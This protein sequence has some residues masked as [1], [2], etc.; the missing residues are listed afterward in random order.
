MSTEIE[1]RVVQLEMNNKSLEKNSKQSIKTLEKL[2]KALEFKNG[3]KSFEDVEKAAEKCNFEPLLKAA[4]TVSTRFSTMGIIGVRALERITDKALD[5]GAALVKSLTIDQITAG[6]SKYEQKTS[7]I[8][9]LVNSTGLSVKEI[10]KYLDQLMWFSDETSYSFTEMVNALATMSASGGDIN[11]LIPMIQG[12]ANATAFAGKGATEFSRIMYNLNQS[13]TAGYLSYMDWK[14]VEQ[15]GAASK[16]LK[17][18]LLDTAVAERKITKGQAD[19]SNFNNLLSK[20]VFTRDI[21]EKSFGYFNEMTQKAYEMIGTL[22][23]QGNVIE[24]ASQAYEILGQQ[25]D[26]VSLRA[27]KSA[28]EAKSFSEAINATKDAVSS[29]WLKMFESIFGDYEQQV[30][31]WTGL[32]EGLYNIFAAP[33]SDVAD[34]IDE[35]FQSTPIGTIEESLADCGIELDAFKEK[36]V[37]TAKA[38]GKFPDELIDATAGSAKSIQDLLSLHW[39]DSSMVSSVMAGYSNA[40]ESGEKVTKEFTTAAELADRM[41]TGEFGN[42][43]NYKELTKNLQEAGYDIANAKDIFKLAKSDP[44]AQIRLLGELTDKNAVSLENAAE[45]AKNFNHEFYASNSGRTIA[46]EGVKNILSAIGDRIAMVKKAW[47]DIFPSATAGSIKNAIIAFHQWTETLKMGEDEGNRIYSVASKVFGALKTGISVVGRIIG[48]AGNLVKSV[49]RI[50]K[51]FFALAPVQGFISSIRT[52]L[53]DIYHYVGNK[54]LNAL[55]W[56]E[57]FINNKLN[58]S[59]DDLSDIFDRISKKLAPLYK[60]AKRVGSYTLGV[61]GRIWQ[62]LSPYANFLYTNLVSPFAQFISEVVNSDDPIATLASGVS[63]FIKKVSTG[64]SNVVQKIK[65]FSISDLFKSANTKFKE[66]LD[67]FPE[68][69]TAFENLQ[70]VVDNLKEHLDF[71]QLLAIFTGAALVV[72]VGKFTKALSDLS[73]VAVEIKKTLGNLNSIIKR[74]S[75]SGFA[76]NMKAI[77]IAIGVLAASLFLLSMIPSEDLS[78]VAKYLGGMMAVLIVVSAVAAIV[79]TKLTANKLQKVRGIIKPLLALSAA[80]LIL[81]IASKNASIAAGEGEGSWK[82]VWKILVVI[83]GLAVELVGVTA[84]LGLLGGKITVAAIVLMVVSVAILKLAQAV[85]LLENIK[86]SDDAIKLGWIVAAIMIVGILASAVTKVGKG[87][88][89]FANAA[90]GILAFVASIYLLTITFEKITSEGMKETWKKFGEHSSIIIPVLAILGGLVIALIAISKRMGEMSKS[91]AKL[92]IGVFAMVGA[93]YLITLLFERLSDFAD[94]DHYWAGWLGVFLIGVI[95]V[96]MVETLGRAAQMSDGGK[97]ALKLA[98]TVIVMTVAIGVMMLLFKAMALLTK[99]MTVEEIWSAIGY[100][101]V[102][103]VI[104]GALTIVA[105]KAAQLGGG[106]GLTIII[107]VIAGMVALVLM[108]ITLTS[109]KLEQIGPAILGILGIAIA[110]GGVIMAVGYAAQAASKNKGGAASL[111]AMMGILLAVGISLSLLAKYGWTQLLAAAVSISAVLAV[112]AG[113]M[114]YMS[115]AIQAVGGSAGSVV[116]LFAVIGVLAAIAGALYF[117]APMPWPQLLAAAGAMAAVLF[118]VAFAMQILGNATPNIVNVLLAV[119]LLRTIFFGLWAIIPAMEAL[120]KVDTMSL[121]INMGI[122]LAAVLLLSL[123][124]A[125]LAAAMAAFPPL[126]LAFVV[127]IGIFLAIAVMMAAVSLAIYTFADAA[128]RLQGVDLFSIAGGMSTMAGAMALVA[129]AGVGLLIGNIGIYAFILAITIL[130]ASMALAS[131][132]ITAFNFALIALGNT[133]SA[134]ANAFQNANGNILGGLANL[135][136]EFAKSAESTAGSAKLMWD[137]IAGGGDQDASGILDGLVSTSGEKG[138]QGGS[139]YG[140]EFTTTAS[141]E[142]SN[143][144]ILSEVNSDAETKGVEG[145]QAYSLAYTENTDIEID[146]ESVFEESTEASKTAG[147]DAATAYVDQFETDFNAGFDELSPDIQSKLGDLFKGGGVDPSQGFSGMGNFGMTGIDFSGTDSDAMKNDISK[148]AN[149]M[150]STDEFN[151]AGQENTKAFVAGMVAYLGSGEASESAKTA[152][153]TWL[154]ENLTPTD[155]WETMTPIGTDIATKIEQEINEAFV[156][157]ADTSTTSQSLL[158]LLGNAVNGTDFTSIGSLIS[159]N[160]MGSVSTSLSSGQAGGEE[161]AVGNFLPLLTSMVAGTDATEPANTLGLSF[162]TKLGA[163]LTSVKNLNDL[164][165]SGVSMGNEVNSGGQSVDTTATGSYWGQGL[166]DGV[167]AWAQRIWQAGYDLA[168][169]LISGTQSGINSHSPSKEAYKLGVY[170][171]MGLIN[172]VVAGYDEVESVAY[173]LGTRAC[174]GLNEG[175]QNG[176]E[177]GIT[178]VIDMSDVMDTLDNFD[179][180]YRPTIKP[181][182]DM[183]DVDPALSNM[184]A[185]AS[186]MG[187]RGVEKSQETEPST[188]ASFNF[189]QNNYSPKALSRIDIYRQ[190]RNQFSTVKEM[191][192]K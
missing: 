102:L 163:S 12:V 28:Q 55:Q 165:N 43:W 177:G 181:R 115:K 56:C 82:K 166:K 111:F 189:T 106:K 125:G 110:L 129:L 178:P 48:L 146:N 153:T 109:F 134:I 17:Q 187:N 95:V 97:G 59:A 190:T 98:A 184:N 116:S 119:L 20:K 159:T 161:G 133:I 172:A 64:L 38:S 34:L 73:G 18:I 46:I 77:S 3:R 57:N 69:K 32:S 89:G 75:G 78:R 142:I 87:M 174:D 113:A 11:S 33:L 168:Q 85:K 167:W 76:A 4:D 144:D 10:N 58:P 50:G 180:T 61:L 52:G 160:V 118:S 26:T 51:A 120:A 47:G 41:M 136:D 19:I 7:S 192:K 88:S 128:E 81:S 36:L 171:D 143:G 107:G 39:V 24:T 94:V 74:K 173:S 123:I 67:A 114:D 164:N 90:L 186:Y 6:Y 179:S 132:S 105:G 103:G 79:A 141:A 2:D 183:S 65:N 185:V 29:Q 96:L 71:G 40:L 154:A 15:A 27:A 137:A 130:G 62:L 8:Q 169:K 68:L 86:L 112:L 156:S 191:I 16:Q 152:I 162:I 124:A 35:A 25:Y 117:L 84:L 150:V 53:S 44:T 37:N 108:M 158:T 135:R 151:N 147:G 155:E 188:P 139:N 121:L 131:I 104:I 149:S 176:V 126:V 72:G 145:A 170:F 21:M 182:L 138:S 93:M 49:I 22:D 60:F 157:T 23:D 45:A 13:Y 66:F 127:V 148:F 100:L 30:E 175:I 14:S 1:N 70:K 5:A 122:L 101:F 9:T 91:L 83:G 63:S 54:I 31:L 92:G 140:Q 42:R 80:M 99:S